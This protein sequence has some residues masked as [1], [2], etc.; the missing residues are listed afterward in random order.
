MHSSQSH[1]LQAAD[2]LAVEGHVQEVCKALATQLFA[3]EPRNRNT[4]IQEVTVQVLLHMWHPQF[5]LLLGAF[6]ASSS[7]A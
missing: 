7:F 6:A 5:V 3:A 4:G 1:R 2:F